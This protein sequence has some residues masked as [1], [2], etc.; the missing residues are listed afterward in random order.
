MAVLNSP[1]L[2]PKADSESRQKQLD[3]RFKPYA[4]YGIG[5]W[6]KEFDLDIDKFKSVTM[7]I[8]RGLGN[9]ASSEFNKVFPDPALQERWKAAMHDKCEDACRKINSLFMD[10]TDINEGAIR[11]ELQVLEDKVVRNENDVLW[12]LQFFEQ[13]LKEPEDLVRDAE[14]FKGSEPRESSMNRPE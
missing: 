2:K 14:D 12:D 4:H 5:Q 8:I 11:K 10:V 1:R 7:P 13:F 9:L 3:A 6:G